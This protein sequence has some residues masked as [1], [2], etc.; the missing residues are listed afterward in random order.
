MD[1]KELHEKIETVVES[2]LKSGKDVERIIE[3]ETEKVAKDFFKNSGNKIDEIQTA[4]VSVIKSTVDKSNNKIVIEGVAKGMFKGAME[5]A[6]LSVK[7]GKDMVENVVKECFSVGLDLKEIPKVIF[8]N[9]KD[10]LTG[11]E[12]KNSK[13]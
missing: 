5:G 7:T 10:S 2:A 11:K 4:I 9:F 3:T 13:L 8:S 6:K 1:L 12:N